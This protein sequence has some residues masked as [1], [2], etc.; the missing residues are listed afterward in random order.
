MTSAP[1]TM[2]KGVK[3]VDLLDV[4]HMIQS[5]EGTSTTHFLTLVL[6]QAWTSSP[7]WVRMRGFRPRSIMPLAC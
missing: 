1:Y 3:L 7:S 4:V 2:K 5:T 6:S